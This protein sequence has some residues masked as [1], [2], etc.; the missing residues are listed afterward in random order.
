MTGPEHSDGDLPDF[1][2]SLFTELE[3]HKKRLIALG[4]LLHDIVKTYQADPSEDARIEEAV[5]DLATQFGLLAEL[6]DSD[7]AAATLWVE[8][9]NKLRSVM[10]TLMGD[11]DASGWASLNATQIVADLEKIRTECDDDFLLEIIKEAY[12]KQI[13]D[14]IDTFAEEVYV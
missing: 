11:R 5:D 6:L 1:D 7:G 3:T 8:D 12:K 10:Y 2:S 4:F 13:Q 9:A 14:D